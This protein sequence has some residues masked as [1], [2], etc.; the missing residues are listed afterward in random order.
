MPH[1]NP[2]G[3]TTQEN[4]AQKLPSMVPPEL[5][6][7]LREKL[8]QASKEKIQIGAV[9]FES[10]GRSQLQPIKRWCVDCRERAFPELDPQ[11][12]EFDDLQRAL[13]WLKLE[14][15]R[16]ILVTV[17][18]DESQIE[19]LVTPEEKENLEVVLIDPQF[20]P[21][22]P[23]EPTSSLFNVIPNVTFDSALTAIRKS[24][25]RVRARRVVSAIRPL[26][27]RDELLAYFKLR[28]RVWTA[29]GY[30]H[31]SVEYPEEGLEINYSDRTAFPLGAFSHEG[32]L[33]GCARLVRGLGCDVPHIV[34]QIEELIDESKDK[35]KLRQDFAYPSELTHPYD[36]LA[37]FPPFTEYYRRLVVENVP[38]AE[39]S[40]VI[41]APEFQG[42]GLG[43]VIVDSLVSYS[44]SLGLTTLFLA[45]QK[46]HQHFYERCGFQSIP[47]METNRFITI[48]A[49]SIAMER[50]DK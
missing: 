50:R 26:Q 1:Q 21:A 23:F 32:Y 24:A 14:R 2:V 11:L 34:A 22:F 13:D 39:V 27:G 44:R 40:R 15:N 4:T 38:K 42:H 37:A 46:K 16:R 18:F 3:E 29:L 35:Q 20:A 6:V 8:D 47:G 43:E 36:V 17:G 12:T 25:I 33:I 7:P 5:A 48:Q 31:Q 49:P 45:C 19:E 9:V 28:Y 10:E 41:I 30:L